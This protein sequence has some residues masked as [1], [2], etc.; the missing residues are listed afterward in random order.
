MFGRLKGYFILIFLLVILYGSFSCSKSTVPEPDWNILRDNSLTWLKQSN[1]ELFQKN[2]K[3]IFNYPTPSRNVFDYIEF[4]LNCA[5]ARAA[6]N[7]GDPYI[8][9]KKADEALL[10]MPKTPGKYSLLFELAQEYSKIHLHRR[11]LEL[12]EEI[13][14][15]F[16]SEKINDFQDLEKVIL[17]WMNR[18]PR[19]MR[20]KNKKN[21]NGSPLVKRLLDLPG[22]IL[23]TPH[24]NEF[25]LAEEFRREEMDGA[26]DKKKLPSQKE[27]PFLLS[28][29]KKNHQPGKSKEEVNTGEIEENRD[30][31]DFQVIE[32]PIEEKRV[33]FDT[34]SKEK[35]LNR[36]TANEILTIPEVKNF[37]S[38]ILMKEDF[39]INS[40]LEDRNLV[41][42]NFFIG[43][44][45]SPF[46]EFRIFILHQSGE[47][48]I[49]L[50]ELYPDELPLI[51]L[52][53]LTSDNKLEII[54]SERGG[55]GGFLSAIVLKTEP[56]RIIWTCWTLYHG[57]I[58]FLD[59]DTDDDLELKIIEGSGDRIVDCNQCP[60]VYHSTLFDY[61][62]SKGKYMP[63]AE[64]RISSEVS[65]EDYGLTGM[66]PHM[67]LS[68]LY[69]FKQT[70]DSRDM[71]LDLF[72]LSGSNIDD[73]L[74]ILKNKEP[75]VYTD[76]L[77]EKIYNEFMTLHNLLKRA[78]NFLLAADLLGELVNAMDS[79]NMPDKWKSYRRLIQM[80]RLQVLIL[81]GRFKDALKLANEK[82]FLEG[83]QSSQRE[84]EIYYN[85]LSVIYLSTGQ[86]EKA[87]QV[88]M[89]YKSRAAPDDEYAVGNLPIYYN[90]VGDYDNAYSHAL[91]TLDL[92]VQN[93]NIVMQ[94]A[95]MIH[96]ASASMN[97]G[98]YPESLQWIT[99]ALRITK[100]LSHSGYSSVLLSI[101]SNIALERGYQNIAIEILDEGAVL[102]DED[103][104][105]TQGGSILFLF[106]K[107]MAD[108][109]RDDIALQCFITGSKISKNTD[110][111][112]YIS[113][114]FEL[115]KMRYKKGDFTGA[116]RYA[117]DAFHSILSTRK[118]I[119]QEH[120]KFTFLAE[121]EDVAYWYFKLLLESGAAG[122]QVLKA[123]ES[124]K[125][126]TFLDIY[127]DSMSNL[128]PSKL[129]DSSRIIYDSLD[130]DEIFLDYIIGEDQSF[131]VVVSKSFGTKIVNLKLTASEIRKTLD[132]VKEYM[133]VRNA[134]SLKHIRRL[135]VPDDLSQKLS[136]LYNLLLTPI[137]I[138]PTVKRIIISPD[139]RIFGVPWP[140]LLIKNDIQLI[141][142][143]ETVQVP[144]ALIA[145][146][147]VRSKNGNISSRSINKKNRALIIGALSS[148]KF[149]EASGSS[150][151]NLNQEVTELPA[152]RNGWSECKAVAHA[153]TSY[154]VQF[155]LDSHTF[156]K[157]RENFICEPATPGNIFAKIKESNI[158]HIVAHGMFNV[159]AP[160][161]SVLFLGNG[162]G[163][164]VLKAYQLAEQDFPGTE[165]VTLAA[166]STGVSLGR[167]GS[168]PIGFVRALFGAG[169]HS[170]LLTEWEVDDKVTAALFSKFYANLSGR[171]KITALR[172]A[173]LYIRRTYKHPYF[174]AGI[175]L[176]GYWK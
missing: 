127:T 97:L 101:A 114:Q 171:Y 73:F 173:Q 70:K 117:R 158:V 172:D 10:P 175:T 115:S 47:G 30:P 31:F 87:Y 52:R 32:R 133:K 103:I 50:A 20:L 2:E 131:V 68:L 43:E 25:K 77:L 122:D 8:L 13:P 140:A 124:W 107:A 137:K 76:E 162:S 37:F 7:Y 41:I 65:L 72:K 61:N 36:S 147:I 89:E 164:N 63:A 40:V 80:K 150:L 3:I 90:L 9:L 59:I 157:R 42:L 134:E 102:L 74:N 99:R 160:M 67:W 169:V 75:S 118:I 135:T 146:N 83:I 29:Y 154:D 163:G 121:K 168:E 35:S 64:D 55:S 105:D 165:L 113:S 19:T 27:L 145:Y 128:S 48:N 39:T 38:Q 119:S 56:L 98:R 132:H 138:P 110:F 15:H 54:I 86:L 78:K 69:Y 82:W 51:Q 159:S 148:V 62:K 16:K 96:L 152:L 130:H 151:Y 155:L 60:C 136:R 66:G 45:D 81:G 53:D 106:G 6:M 58:D 108:L 174:W 100:S 46:G 44:S 92:A 79:D 49:T 116:L 109:N 139:R 57:R 94:S 104:W 33:I 156:Q 4:I 34:F 123:V 120:Q 112:V 14:S 111:T 23:D 149:S 144:S 11:A 28:S 91:H 142:K 12:A 176:H 167:P 166:C 143:Y 88:L 141:D 17:E 5:K 85:T 26:G 129:M 95:A 170:L 21:S 22:V 161:Q 153:L 125:M 71:L 24:Y 1:R 18:N 84:I 93:E 126:Q